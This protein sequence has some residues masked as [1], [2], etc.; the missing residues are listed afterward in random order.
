MLARHTVKYRNKDR[1][2][3]LGSGFIIIHS[4]IYLIAYILFADLAGIASVITSHFF[5]GM[6]NVPHIQ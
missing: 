1:V 6:V 5:V 3:K 2:S 4:L